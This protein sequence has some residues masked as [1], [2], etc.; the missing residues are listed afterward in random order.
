MQE[1]GD[2]SIYLV[3]IEVKS[4]GSRLSVING[5]TDLRNRK[6]NVG[7][8]LLLLYVVVVVFH[9]GFQEVFRTS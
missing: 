5:K 7:M 9:R 8:T 1:G 6:R 2:A 3:K 4:V